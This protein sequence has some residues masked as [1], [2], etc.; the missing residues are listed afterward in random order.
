MTPGSDDDWVDGLSGR[1][2]STRAGLEGALLQRALAQATPVDDAGPPE[3]S[4][5]R[6]EQ[7]LERA[8]REQLLPAPAQGPWRRKWMA[9]AAMLTALTIGMSWLYR[10]APDTTAA[11]TTLGDTMIVRG[12]ADQI[13][14]IEVADPAAAQGRLLA[15]LRAVGIEG[16][17]YETLGRYGIDAD[18]PVR[19]TAGQR[20]LL[21]RYRISEPADHVL[22]LEFSE[23][24]R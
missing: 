4:P 16:A 24:Q 22:K 19:I 14:R 21:S 5:L 6:E 3:S 2:P 12:G 20:Q 1:G 8:R 11:D 10:P 9:L 18:L 13:V 23:P 17:G 15:E 7:L